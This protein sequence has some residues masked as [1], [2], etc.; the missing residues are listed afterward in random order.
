MQR[1]DSGRPITHVVNIVVAFATKL[2][3]TV[4]F[5]PCVL[6]LANPINKF[7]DLPEAGSILK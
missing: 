1:L 4:H 2:E 6:I 7:D 5:A 3:G